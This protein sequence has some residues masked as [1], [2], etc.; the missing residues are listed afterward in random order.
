MFVSR[1]KTF[2]IS[3]LFLI[4]TFISISASDRS[5]RIAI[6]TE[7]VQLSTDIAFDM[8]VEEFQEIMQMEVENNMST[9]DFSFFD[10]STVGELKTGEFADLTTLGAGSQKARNLNAD[11]LILGYFYLIDNR[12]IIQLNAVNPL[13][14]DL[15]SSVLKIARQNISFYN[16]LP[17]TMERFK[18]GI[19]NEKETIIKIADAGIQPYTSRIYIDSR[20][21]DLS[22]AMDGGEILDTFTGEQLELPLHPEPLGQKMDIRYSAEGYHS[23]VESFYLDENIKYV[24]LPRLYP[25]TK[26]ALIAEYAIGQ[27]LGAGI[28]YRGYPAIDRFYLSL[29]VYGFL[30]NS[31]ANLFSGVRHLDV[32]PELGLYISPVKNLFRWGISGG[33]GCIFTFDTGETTSVYTDLYVS[34]GLFAELNFRDIAV[35]LKPQLKYTL[36]IGNNHLGTGILTKGFLIPLSM[37]VIWKL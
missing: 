12:I 13:S 8:S 27:M 7:S 10:S 20:Q 1:L 23:A 29:G 34:G 21:K 35:Y 5:L 26:Q 22:I 9:S 36:G 16:M 28:V 17:G 19:L 11:L 3:S 25:Q 18:E 32:Y 6:Y 24:E 2:I 14:G 31:D 37:G 15:V 33:G 4:A 30:N